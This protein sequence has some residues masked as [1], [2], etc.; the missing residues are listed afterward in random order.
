MRGCRPDTWL[1]T[2]VQ[3]ADIW[4]RTCWKQH[5]QRREA[6]SVTTLKFCKRKI[7]PDQFAGHSG[8]G[9]GQTNAIW[10]NIHS[11]K[12]MCLAA[13]ATMKKIYFVVRTVFVQT[14]RFYS[15]HWFGRTSLDHWHRH[16][17]CPRGFGPAHNEW[18][19]WGILDIGHYLHRV[20]DTVQ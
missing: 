1:D 18:R 10:M 16:W 13:R 4:S 19:S 11:F 12:G 14:W 5:S 20:S 7:V 17:F 6:R 8:F 15:T 3:P 2:V 9:V